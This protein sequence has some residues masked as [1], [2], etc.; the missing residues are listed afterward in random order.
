MKQKFQN[1]DLLKWGCV[2]RLLHYYSLAT[3]EEIKDGK[4]WY[5]NANK[6]CQSFEYPLTQVAGITAA[7]SPQAG[8]IENKRY[9]STYLKTGKVLRTKE[10]KRKAEAILNTENEVEIL[11]LLSVRGLALKSKAFYLNILHPSVET[12]VT[13]DRHAVAACLQH[14]LET[15][16]L[17][18][19]RLTKKQYGFFVECYKDAAK[20]TG[21]LPH[22]FQA[23][24]WVVYR[25][26]KNLNNHN[27][28]SHTENDPF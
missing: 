18:E 1:R 15:E 23:V 27:E 5:N 8:W 3:R 28:K 10:Q 6:F 14:Y 25:R 26:L 13:I 16:S 11:N 4:E 19:V 24:V 12:S 17:G 20:R 7:F 21:L 9:V 2:Q 22:Q